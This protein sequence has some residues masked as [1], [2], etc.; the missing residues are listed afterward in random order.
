MGNF[1]APCQSVERHSG[2][3]K[4]EEDEISDTSSV[5]DVVVEAAI[6]KVQKTGRRERVYGGGGGEEELSYE[7]KRDTT[8]TQDEIRFLERCCESQM[9]FSGFDDDQR[10]A[11]ISQMYKVEVPQGTDIIEQGDKEAHLFYVIQEGSF[12]IYVNNIKVAN[13]VKGKSFGELALMYD[14]PRAATVRAAEDSTLFAV[15]R[16][17]FRTALRHV[18]KEQGSRNQRFLRS[19]KEFEHFSDEEIRLIDM[20]L[21]RL[22]FQKGE[23]IIRQNE[24][25]SDRF[26]MIISGA[27]EWTKTSKSGELENGDLTL[28][29]C[30]GERA[31]ITNEKRAATVIAKT[32]VTTLTLSREDFTDLLGDGDIFAE[33]LNSYDRVSQVEQAQVKRVSSTSS[34]L[35]LDVCDLEELTENTVGVLGQGAFGVVTLVADPNTQMSYALKAIKK[36][37]IVEL[38]QQK[39][40]VNEMKIMRRLAENYCPFLVNLVATFKDDLRVYFLL[41]VCLGG[42]LFTI[43]RRRRNFDEKT[44][45]FYTACVTEAFDFMHSQHIIYRDLKPENLVLNSEGYLKITDFGFA[46]EVKHKTFTLCGT[47]DYLAPE[48]VTGKGHNKAVDWWTLGVLLYEMVASIPPFYDETPI[49]TYRR[50]IKA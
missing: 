43:L 34:S 11:V 2:S 48:I 6:L 23:V 8:K 13:F 39:H 33:K 4:L 26:Y 28:G 22:T 41:D 16:Q 12:D 17:A 3:E 25:R 49:N 38:K 37:Q 42:E 21:V 44:A 19:I 14:A 31:L 27:C 40:I 20:A 5:S 29:S 30:F 9:L 24:K 45:R 46:K 18:M 15:H 10:T 35:K 32:S 50:I 47:P 36:C 7:E 1:L